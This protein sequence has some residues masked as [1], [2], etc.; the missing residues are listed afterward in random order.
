MTN[1][2]TTETDLGRVVYEAFWEEHCPA[3][4]LWDDEETVEESRV[5][6]R[7]IAAAVRAEVEREMVARVERL[8]NSEYMTVA[9]I[10][11]VSGF[12]AAFEAMTGERREH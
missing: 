9:P 8:A 2:A 12:Y 3:N 11:Y 5:M 4:S 1:T 6:W 10:G 7:G